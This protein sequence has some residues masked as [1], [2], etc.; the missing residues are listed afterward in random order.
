MIKL[1]HSDC[2]EEMS[3]IEADSTEAVICDPP[4]AL[5]FMGKAFDK[6]DSPQHYQQWTLSW[7]AEALRVLKPG[8][9]LLAFGGT[10]TSHR[11]VC[12]LEE[13]G[14]V[15][16]D[17]LSWL[18][19]SGF[20]KSFNVSKG[21]DKKNDRLQSEYMQLAEYLK[22]KRINRGYSLKDV[23]KH[24]PSKTGGLT[25]CVS[26]WESGLSVPTK[27]QWII[28]NK[29]LGL[30]GEFE[31]FIN[32]IEIE[33]KLMGTEREVVGRHSAPAKSIYGTK[34]QKTLNIT[35]PATD[36]AKTWEGYGTGLKPAHEPICL[37]QKPLDDN[38]CQNIEKHGV[39]ALNIDAG[40]IEININDINRRPNGSIPLADGGKTSMFK[41]GGRNYKEN[42]GDTL[43]LYKG[44]FP[45]NLILDEEAAAILDEQ[46]GISKS[47][48][49]SGLAS[50]FP[51]R[52]GHTVGFM[53]GKNA[54]AGGLG[55]VGGASRFFYCAKASKAERGD[56]N[57]HPTVKPLALLMYLAKLVLP[58]HKSVVWLDPFM[59][60]GSSAL[61]AQKLNNEEGYQINFIGIEQEA[62]YIEIAKNRLEGYE[63]SKPKQQ[64][65][66]S[67][68]NSEVAHA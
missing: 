47:S 34:S 50:Q 62:E 25:G 26:N 30:D 23:A 41:M 61:A 42:K 12:G 22:N 29:L 52:N 32:K 7:A 10:R 18:Y 5:A 43:N 39:G 38:Y 2:I 21:F 59:G 64:H 8:G 48:G 63:Q 15:I 19:G 13:A 65:L 54:N 6:F 14:F 55:D 53:S 33:R 28:L 20:P 66:M 58:H 57:N 44:R 67:A 27:K 40:R 68:I 1:I 51:K 31:E 24:F 4:Y 16:R 17:T 35:A 60:S 49:G 37:A 56:G 46:S 9:Y 45:A 3:K 11:L 36:P